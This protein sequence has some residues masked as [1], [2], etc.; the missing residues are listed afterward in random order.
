MKFVYYSE[1]GG[2]IEGKQSG[3]I[4][5]PNHPFGEASSNCTWTVEINRSFLRTDTAPNIDVCIILSILLVPP[6]TF[7]T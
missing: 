5:S 1:C 3:V 2:L 6:H 7:L 4:N